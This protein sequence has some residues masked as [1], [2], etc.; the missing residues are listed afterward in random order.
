MGVHQ[1]NAMPSCGKL[2]APDTTESDKFIDFSYYL[3]ILEIMSRECYI[4]LSIFFLQSAWVGEAI[5]IWQLKAV[6]SQNL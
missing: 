6:L 2:I 3:T 4:I 1:T 5:H